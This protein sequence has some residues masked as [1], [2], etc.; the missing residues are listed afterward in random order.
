MRTGTNNYDQGGQCER[1]GMRPIQEI[2]WRRT[3]LRRMRGRTRMSWNRVKRRRGSIGG[4]G[5]MKVW[6]DCLGGSTSH[7][8]PCAENDEINELAI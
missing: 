3:K 2:S 4:G 1:L 6:G 7:G 8:T 5:L